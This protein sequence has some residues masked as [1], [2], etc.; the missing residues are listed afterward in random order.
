M[1]EPLIE[2]INTLTGGIYNFSLK[3]ATLDRGADFCMLE[4]Y[5][6]DGTILSKE[7][8]QKVEDKIYSLVPPYFD[9]EIK[10]IKNFISEELVK[11]KFLEFLDKNYPAIFYR[12]QSVSREDLVFKI[13]FFID[14]LSFDY[15]VKRNIAEVAKEYLGSIFDG[16]LFDIK[17]SK[18]EMVSVDNNQTEKEIYIEKEK[19]AMAER[20]IEFYG[21]IKLVGNEILEPASYI[22]DK[23]SPEENVVLCG[24][25]KSIKTYEIK[26]KAKEEDE[27][28]SEGEGASKKKKQT[29]EKTMFKWILEDY[30]SS[31]ECVFFSSKE[32]KKKVEKFDV[33]TVIAVR[34]KVEESKF[35]SEPNFIV[36]DISYCSLPEKF[37]EKI[38]YHIEKP[39]Y[40]FVQ[41]EKIVVYEQNTLLDFGEEKQVPKFLQNKTFVCYDFETTGLHFEAGDRIIEIGA[42]KIENGKITEKFESLVDPGRPISPEASKVSGITDADVAG[43]LKDYE[44]LQD[45]YKF[46]R[47]AILVGYNSINFD[48]V[49]LIGQGKLARWNFDNAVDDVYRYAQKFVHGVK[50]YKQITI[51]EKLGV[52]LDNAHRAYYDAL[53]TAEIF[54]KLAEFIKSE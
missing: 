41:P 43:A 50:N 9:T 54:I 13:T 39:F 25:I 31:I 1:A 37:E 21:N 33:G 7:D 22:K 40:E 28:N 38:V 4:I 15:A 12:F 42:V 27:T 52:T 26:K 5:Y 3:S 16:Y 34:G 51:A 46:T 18:D 10:F 8:K 30:T 6:A 36:H 23:T 49:F 2:E 20:S 24:T 47:G 11:I 14:E 45:F 19:D 53:A 44:V 17:F 48:N 29:R 32:N 35:S